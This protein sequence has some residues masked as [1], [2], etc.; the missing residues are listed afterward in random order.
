MRGN[1]KR[2]FQE[3]EWG[4]GIYDLDQNRDKWQNL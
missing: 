3:V 4:L 2:E 1:T